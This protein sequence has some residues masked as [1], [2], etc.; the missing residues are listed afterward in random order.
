[1][2]VRVPFNS[3]HRT[4]SDCC[5]FIQFIFSQTLEFVTSEAFFRGLSRAARVNGASV[6]PDMK[7]GL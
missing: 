1:M 4:A 3:S 7:G 5:F 2:K 6:R